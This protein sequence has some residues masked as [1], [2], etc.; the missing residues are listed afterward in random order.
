MHKDNL[1][2]GDV[3]LGLGMALAQNVDAMRVFG[4]LKPSQQQY[5]IEK[6]RSI[7]SKKEMQSFVDGLSTMGFE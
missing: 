5:I 1:L 3:P 2:S 7:S 4:G 6:T